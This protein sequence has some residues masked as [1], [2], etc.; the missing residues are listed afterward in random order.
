EVSI[1]SFDKDSGR[2]V[3]EALDE[4]PSNTSP[5][6]ID[7]AKR[8][9]LIV[10]ANK[11]VAALDPLTGR[12][13]WRQN[14][15]S[16]GNYA[17]PTPVW[18]DDLLLLDGLMLKLNSEQPGASILWPQNT[19]PVNIHVSDTSTPMLQ[20][21]LAFFPTTKGNLLCRD[22]ANGKQLWQAEQISSKSG[23]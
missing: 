17:V 14:V 10:W 1:I 6:V 2:Q 11:S 18:R 20:D 3:W 7:S 16:A 4:I 21:G 13:L 12:M 9:Q 5:I 15:A 23:P 8:R 19:S 22:A